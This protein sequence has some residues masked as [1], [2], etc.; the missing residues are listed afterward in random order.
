MSL[1]GKKLARDGKANGSCIPSP[2]RRDGS[3]LSQRERA[4]FLELITAACPRTRYARAGPQERAVFLDDCGASP[5]EGGKNYVP[6]PRRHRAT[7]KGEPRKGVQEW[8][9]VGSLESGE[10]GGLLHRPC[11]LPHAPLSSWYF[12]VTLC[13]CGVD[14]EFPVSSFEFQSRSS[15]ATTEET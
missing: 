9:T 6:L 5:A 4:V 13:L 8:T 12:S 1:S 15:Y 10:I 14:P 3:P 7:E 2:T 11:P